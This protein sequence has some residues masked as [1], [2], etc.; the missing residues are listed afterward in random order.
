MAS[1]Q[2]VVSTNTRFGIL[3]NNFLQISNFSFPSKDNQFLSI[4]EKGII[5]T[6]S[7]PH[8]VKISDA[9]PSDNAESRAWIE[10]VAA[11]SR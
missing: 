6:T 5:D 11:N 8:E 1:H 2:M 10:Y 3:R 9:Y 4:E 7:G